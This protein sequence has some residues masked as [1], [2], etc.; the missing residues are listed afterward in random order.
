MVSMA[1]PLTD[2]RNAFARQ[3]WGEA[4]AALAAERELT[5]ADLERLAVAAHL[6]G[7][8]GDSAR[9]WERAHHAFAAA[10]D[11]D[12]SARC[13]AWLGIALLLRGEMA[14]GAGWLARAA[15]LLDDAGGDW[16]ARGY[17]LVPTFIEAVHRDVDAAD[18]IADEILGI[19]HRFGEKDLFALGM[20]CRGEAALAHGQVARGM[21]VFDE[22]MVAVATG[23]VSPLAAGIVYCGVIEACMIAHDLRRAGE[24]TAELERWC[25]AQP[26]LVPYRGQCLVHRSQVLQAHGAW[27]DAVVAA[28]R[29]I[30]HLSATAHPAVGLALYQQAELHRLHGELADAERAYR[31]A[32][33]HRLEPAP[34]FALLRL[35]ERKLSAAVAAIRRMLDESRDHPRRPTML[36][37][38][39]EIML[40]AGDL[41]AAR[42]AADELA[43]IAAIAE[44]SLLDAVA[45]FAVGSVRLAQGDATS[46]LAE[47]RRACVKWNELEMPYDVARARVQIGFACRALGDHDAAELELA[48]ARAAFE[49]LGARPDLQRLDTAAPVAAQG[50]PAGLTARECEVLRL[51]A[52]GETNRAIATALVISEHT[53]GRHLQN[54]FA[55]LGVSSR[56]A[57]T[58]YAYEHGLA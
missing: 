25:A 46:A 26:D 57:A 14:Q 31:A 4:Y 19:A 9:A 22:A 52:T 6:V 45:A 17:L 16:A 35:A 11:A 30:E 44:V 33:Q 50:R 54:I 23:D 29:A 2:A 38:F 55:K 15:R 41:D 28:Q 24:W 21:N 20:L 12:G 3:A 36:A 58:A 34:G 51:V 48:N 13:G 5:A 18:A 42:E 27:T 40:V 43:T 49:R 37:A 39:I 47:L 32:S 7:R 56:A 8:D 53:V 10:N 1:S